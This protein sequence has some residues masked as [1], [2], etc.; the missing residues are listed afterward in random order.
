MLSLAVILILSYLVGSI[1]GSLWVGRWIYG[2]DLRKH[3]SGNPGAT[4]AYRILGWKAGLLSTVVDMGKGFVAAR[5]V[6]A[7]RIDALPAF[8]SGSSGWL[9]VALVAGIAAV[10]GHMFPVFAGF[11]GGKGVNTAAGILLAV[12]PLNMLITFLAFCLVL[13]ATR[14]VSLSSMIGAISYPVSLIVQKYVLGQSDVETSLVVF[15][16]VLASFIVLAHRSNIKRLFAG[17]EN[18][19]SWVKSPVSL[20]KAGE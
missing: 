12:T 5:F 8:L 6:A 20:E 13:W 18:R 17:T 11:K 9:I 1:P 19:I 15:G 4:N 10:I 2:V 16:V 3:G 14:Y 7:L